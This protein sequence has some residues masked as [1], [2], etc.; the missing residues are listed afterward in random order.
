M[1]RYQ[2]DPD[3]KV[4]RVLTMLGMTR[5]IRDEGFHPHC[6]GCPKIIECGVPYDPGSI[7]ECA[8]RPGPMFQDW[9][10]RHQ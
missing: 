3:A 6:F 4:E 8:E 10:R 5:R 1:G 2:L 7:V 9:M